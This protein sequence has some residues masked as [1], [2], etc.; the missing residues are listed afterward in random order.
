M[1]ADETIECGTDIPDPA[2]VD[3]T[4]NCDPMPQTFMTEE[5]NQLDC[6]Y[7]IVRTYRS[8]DECGNQALQV[9]TITVTDSTDS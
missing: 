2:E 6:G 9:Q 7:E 4:D 5:I 8:T 3:A 1:P